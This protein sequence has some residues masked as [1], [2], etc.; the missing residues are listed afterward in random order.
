MA[1]FSGLLELL[2]IHNV[3]CVLCSSEQ[4]VYYKYETVYVG[5]NETVEL[6]CYRFDQS[7][8]AWRISKKALP[9]SKDSNATDKTYILYT[10]GHLLNPKL[11]NTNIDIIG[12][13]N[14]GKCNLKIRRFTTVDEGSYTCKFWSRGLPFNLTIHQV[15][16]K[17]GKK[18]VRG[19]EGK[20]LTIVCTVKSGRLAATL[21]LRT[22]GIS[23]WKERTDCVTY[24]FIPTK[25]ENM[26]SIVCSA[27]STVLD[28]PLSFKVQLD[29][30]YSPVVEITRRQTE[31]KLIL[32]CNPS[33]NPENY[34]FGN[35]E[36]WSEFKEHIQN[37]EGTP[38][39]TLPLPK[40]TNNKW[41]P[42]TDGIY[43]CKAS[44]GI[45]GT[46]GHLYQIGTTLVHN[47]V[48]PIF[49]ITNKPIQFG[50]Y[51]QKMNLTVLLYN[52]YG[53]I[54]T[55]ISK[56]NEPLHTETIQ[57][58][59]KTQDISHDVIL[60]VSGIKIT[61]Q[62]TLDKIEDFTDYTIKAC[63]EMGCNELTVK[64]TP[65]RL[66]NNIYDVTVMLF[67]SLVVIAVALVKAVW[68]VVLIVLAVVLAITVLT[69]FFTTI[70]Y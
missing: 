53:T 36:H 9:S 61:F 39:G 27:Y 46:N 51:G 52:K 31:H 25:K 55:T 38:D 12:G 20:N 69:A 26:Q 59:I 14:T 57:E 24:S 44:N 8:C 4:D 16:M 15:I 30:Q 18:V 22:N 62:L 7:E 6:Y 35:W 3:L 60:T 54:Q 23:T 56:Q 1:F 43:K 32:I 47:K 49:V 28:N 10:D 48:P 13:N 40:S 11:N 5:T 34:T 45:Y 29:I 2:V 21:V 37:L 70:A 63:N 58:T 66:S 64:I 33:G 17:K 68:I 65:A 41:F 50:R 19:I 67:V 42:E